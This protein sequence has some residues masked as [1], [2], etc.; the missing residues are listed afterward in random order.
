M[1]AFFISLALFC[2]WY[3]K[4]QI[5]QFDPDTLEAAVTSGQTVTVTTILS[6][7]SELP[8]EFTFPGYAGRDWGGPDD[9][10]Y[11]WIDSDEEGGPAWEYNDISEN[12]TLIE[13]FQD[14]NTVGPFEFGFDFPFYGSTHSLFYI[15]ANGCIVFNNQEIPYTNSP[16]P[17]LSDLNGFIAWF[18]DDLQPL[19][20][21][22]KV[23]IKHFEDK[24]IVQYN[25]FVQ[26]EGSSGYIFGQVVMQAN[27]DILLKYRHI[28]EGFDASAG[29]VGIQALENDLGLQVVC[30]APYLHPEMII[31]F[32]YP[33]TFIHA[34]EPVSGYLEP[35]QQETIYIVYNSEGYPEGT[36][37]AEL[38]CVTNNPAQLEVYTHHIMH[39]E[40]PVP[41]GFFGLVTDA[42]T[43]EPIHGVKVRAGDQYVFTNELGH[44]EL[45]LAQGIY[46]VKFQK[47]GYETL[48]VE[49]TTALPGFSTLD[50]ELSGFY[51]MVGRVWAGEQP[52]ET[53]FAY[54]YKMQE[55][56]VVD[57]FAEMVGE[58]GHY[59]FSGMPVGQYIIKAEP[60]P[61][62]V[63][64]GLYLP[65][66]YGDALHWEDATIVNLSQNTDGL[67]IHL[68]PV[69]S[70]PQ[71][72]GSISGEIT[73]GYNNP[74][75]ANIPII[76]EST[77]SDFSSMTF[78]GSDGSF[79]FSN[80]EFGTYELFAEI[81]GK[82]ITPM[83][84]TL[85]EN[86]SSIGGISMVILEEEIIFVGISEPELFEFLSLPF[87]NPAGDR[88]MMDYR[89]NEPLETTVS[90]IDHLGRMIDF[91]EIP[92]DISGQIS[93]NVKKLDIGIYVV[94]ISSPLF[95]N[96]IR[97]FIK[98]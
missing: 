52:I 76:L 61:N 77:T 25:K 56:V 49:D 39:V 11:F 2:F 10:G 67:Q 59:E 14:D 41:A 79:S 1:K 29:T 81:P 42:S 86:S 40:N 60:S 98:K 57:V 80:L 62:S 47:E 27:G 94:K 96:S 70:N 97:V 32:D 73:L 24:V 46:D 89:L 13:G 66:Y 78:S 90:I 63:Y 30:N 21:L 6:N 69:A 9:F 15:S 18:W 31:R 22:S 43:G 71:G 26:Y 50:A 72:S 68:I 38:K 84:I 54:A 5:I 74:P 34:V 83:V 65:T 19:N 53:G 37:T 20:D 7:V 33:G 3:S 85:E 36:Y 35:G 82:S 44:Y 75:A 91:Y 51:Y 92:L 64:Y 93:M 16:I 45:P 88:I 55:D 95:G 23:F 4:A 17:T 87:P 8:V 28:Y 48:V 12:G 58:E